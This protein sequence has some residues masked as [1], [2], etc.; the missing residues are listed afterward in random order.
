MKKALLTPYHIGNLEIKNRVIMSPMNIGAL[1]NSDGS[2]SERGINYFVERAKGGV[3]MITT[4]SVRVTREFE[5][6]KDTIPLW[7]AFADHKIHTGWINELAERCHDYDCKVAVQLTIGGGRQAGAFSQEHGLAIGPSA[8]PCFYPP[9]KLTREL[10]KQEIQKFLQAIKFSASIIK[11]A[12]ADAINLHGHEG[13][14]MDEFT[15]SLWNHRTD[16]YGGNLENRLRFIKEIINAIREG[17]GSDIPIIYRFGLTHYVEGGRTIEEGLQMAQMLETYGVNALDIDA[18]CYDSWYYAHP[19]TTM[20]AGVFKELYKQAKNVVSIPIIGSGKVSYPEIAEDIIAN[21]YADFVSL[22]RPLIADAEWVKKVEMNQEAEIRP[23]IGCHQGCMK[24][25]NEFKYVSCAVNPCAGNE[26]YLAISKSEVR[27]NILVIGGGVAGMV[28]A[29][30]A[31]KRGHKVI[32]L[33]K[34]DGLGGNF[35]KGNNPSFKYDYDRYI[36]YLKDQLSK[37]TTKVYLNHVFTYDD[38]TRMKPDNVI[39]AVGASFIKQF[40]NNAKMLNPFECLKEQKYTGKFAII[41]GGLVG[42]EVALNIA[43]NG[44]EVCIVEQKDAVAMDMF[45]ANRDHFMRLLEENHVRI[46]TSS[47]LS[48]I[49]DDCYVL[50]KNGN[51]VEKMEYDYQVACIGMRPNIDVANELK[52]HD[53]PFIQ[54]GD[55]SEVKNVLSAVWDAYRKVRLI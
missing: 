23:C 35:K 40:G 18:G 41:G 29:I 49:G 20:P 28:A 39:V 45:K 32:L 5:R 12:G 31:S 51:C 30:T 54:I 34:T 3:G 10:S 47:K 42:C 27:K 37:T 36:E 25:L 8:I 7:M 19:P 4:G 44:G 55:C 16:E 38:I 11:T 17:A 1:N 13:Y 14:L 53:V 43:K 15:T 33:E 26:Q 22:G 52:K 9:H 50:D 21:G 46:L 6:S 24:R 48:Y 2:I